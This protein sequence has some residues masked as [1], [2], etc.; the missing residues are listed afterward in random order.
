MSLGWS[1]PDSI[2]GSP[3]PVTLTAWKLAALDV[4]AELATKGAITTKRI[5]EL[6]VHPG[7]WTTARWLEPAE[8]R[9]LWVRGARCPRFDEQH[10][11]AYAAALAKAREGAA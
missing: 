10:P 9:G 11:T 7:R 8:T 3:C 2:A 1:R 5:R 4:L 6:G